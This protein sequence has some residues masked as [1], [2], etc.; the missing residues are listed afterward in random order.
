MV[1][2]IVERNGNASKPESFTDL[3]VLEPDYRQDRPQC[4]EEEARP[5]AEAVRGPQKSSS[6][7]LFT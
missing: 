5:R 6:L 3:E 7:F 4:M 2:R 1:Y